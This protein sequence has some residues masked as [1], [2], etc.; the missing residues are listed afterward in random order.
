M[1]GSAA[2]YDG[3]RGVLSLARDPRSDDRLLQCVKANYG[4]T[5]WGAR[6]IERTDDNGAFRG[7]TL[8]VRM[9]RHDLSEAKAAAR[10]AEKSAT[11]TAKARREAAKTGAPGTDRDTSADHIL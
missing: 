2:W 6:L 8:G 7:L 3:A 5:G 1:A 9:A 4:R 10:D 11:T